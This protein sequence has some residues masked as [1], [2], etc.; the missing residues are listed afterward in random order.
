MLL[1]NPEISENNEVLGGNVLFYDKNKDKV[2]KKAKEVKS[3]RIT[4]IFTGK[5]PKNSH[6]IL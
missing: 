5:Q 3:D 4:I 2:Y 1:S 6:L